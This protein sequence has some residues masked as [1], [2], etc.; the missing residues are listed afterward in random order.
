VAEFTGKNLVVTFGGTTISGNQRSF[1]VEEEAGLVDASAG[2]DPARTY[3][4][5]LEDGTATLEVLAQDDST[6]IW[7]ACRQGTSGSLVWGEEGNGVGNPRHTVPA[8]VSS[9]KKDMPYDD[10]VV[11]TFEFQFSGLVVDDTY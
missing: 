11:M 10:V 5:T 9:R 3:L 4:K 2:N 8:V 6:A 1:S 7:A